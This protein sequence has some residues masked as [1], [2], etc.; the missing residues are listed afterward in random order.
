MANS[1]NGVQLNTKVGMDFASTYNLPS[2]SLTNN[3]TLSNNPLYNLAQVIFNGKQTDNIAQHS[4]SDYINN[5][6]G[7]HINK[8]EH[9]FI[10]SA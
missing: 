10:T 9:K 6:L 1:I 3:T 8:N 2:T 7:A 4:N 5:G